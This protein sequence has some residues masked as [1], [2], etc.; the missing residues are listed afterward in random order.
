MC[1]RSYQNIS[2]FFRVSSIAHTFVCGRVCVCLC[3]CMCSY[4]NISKFFGVS[5]IAN[6]F[7]CGR[8]CVLMYVHAFI[9]KHK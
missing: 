4:Q 9:S 8:V 5:S 3:T 6:T 2:K 1:M 7:V